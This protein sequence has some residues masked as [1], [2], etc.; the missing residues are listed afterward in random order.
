MTHAHPTRCQRRPYAQQQHGY[1][2]V[3]GDPINLV[4]ASGLCPANYKEAFGCLR[5]RDELRAWNV[6]VVWDVEAL[7]NL[8]CVDGII[9]D[10]L[11]QQGVAQRWTPNEMRSIY[12]AF[13]I[14][15]AAQKKIGF[16]YNLPLENGIIIRKRYE[17]GIANTSQQGAL[18]LT[19][20][21]TITLSARWWGEGERDPFTYD[22]DSSPTKSIDAYGDISDAH[23]YRAWITLHEFNHVV[24][25]DIAGTV[26]PGNADTQFVN[27]QIDIRDVYGFPQFGAP[28]RYAY[29]TDAEYIVESMTG[30]LWNQGHQV[31][32]Y[33]SSGG[34]RYVRNVS[35]IRGT[36]RDSTTLEEWIIDNILRLAA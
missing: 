36:L 5:M 14:F 31:A 23:Q 21:R 10:A 11:S 24:V 16:A 19:V 6:N 26:D 2:Y 12:N 4:D 34:G 20:G 18:G 28:T 15:D 17:A 25:K 35:E 22:G 33:N 9:E 30:T 27:W 13:R 29:T 3:E 8:T 1:M 7:N 32:R